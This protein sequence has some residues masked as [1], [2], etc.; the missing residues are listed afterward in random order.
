MPA[1]RSLAPARS[2]GDQGRT[3]SAK[4][5]FISAE[6]RSSHL[7]YLSLPEL[8]LLGPPHSGSTT[9]WKQVVA[10]PNARFPVPQ[11]HSEGIPETEKEPGYF[12]YATRFND[13]KKWLG[14]F[15]ERCSHKNGTTMVDGTTMAGVIEAPARMVRTYTKYEARRDRL[16]SHLRMVFLV[17]EPLAHLGSIINY[18]CGRAL[19]RRTYLRCPFALPGH[20]A[21][22]SSREATQRVAWYLNRYTDCTAL[23]RYGPSQRWAACLG[24]LKA[25]K[26]GPNIDADVATISTQPILVDQALHWVRYVSEQQLLFVRTEDITSGVA[27]RAIWRFAGLAEHEA[28]Q[29]NLTK[30]ALQQHHSH[31][32]PHPLATAI[33]SDRDVSRLYLHHSRRLCDELNVGCDHAGRSRWRG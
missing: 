27:A 22:P 11:R 31:R 14:R 2:A 24:A 13:G 17:R 9:L 21:T 1:Q 30:L 16:P 23:P 18:Y 29:A 32:S 20:N 15:R 19:W 7:F 26:G 28:G 10:H 8:Y 25:L 5:T 6:H 12:A 3:A 4:S 33:S